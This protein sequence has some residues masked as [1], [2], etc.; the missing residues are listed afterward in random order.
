MDD[1]VLEEAV[2]WVETSVALARKPQMVG[3]DG[4]RFAPGFFA[5]GHG[6][7]FSF[8]LWRSDFVDL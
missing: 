4:A 3:A 1:R 8:Q 2:V 6:V 5:L 7:D